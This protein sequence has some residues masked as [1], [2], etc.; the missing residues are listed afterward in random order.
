ML[1]VSS[2]GLA[3]AATISTGGSE[4]VSAHGSDLD[5]A[6]SGGKQF[7][8]GVAIGA[9]VFA[10]SQVVQ[11]TV[12]SGGTGIVSAHGSDFGA[13][14]S[15][16]IELDFGLASGATIYAGSQAA[17]RSWRAVS[18]PPPARCL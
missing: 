8:F 12:L 10:G 16:G 14:I 7:D 9:T 5:V 11:S 4:T 6:I 15:G 2:G 3:Q 13:Q 1:L 18:P 17:A